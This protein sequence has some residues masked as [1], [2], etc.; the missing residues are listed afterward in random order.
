MSVG[1]ATYYVDGQSGHDEASGLS[2]QHAWKSLEHVNIHIFQAGDKLL[3]Q[4]GTRYVGQLK[5]QGSG[6]IVDGKA[7]NPSPSANMARARIRGLMAKAAFSTHCCSAMSSSGKCRI[8]RSPTSAPTAQP[9]R[10]GVR[11]VCDGFGAM[12][13]IHLRSL[14]VHDVNGDLRKRSR[15]LRHFLREPRRQSTRISMTRHRELP[16]SSAPIATAYAS[17]PATGARSLRRGHSRQSAGRHRRR[18]HQ[19]LGQQR[20]ARS[21]TTFC[22]ADACAARTTRLGYGR[23]IAT[24]RSSSSTKSR[25]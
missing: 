11:V 14:F 12:R 6:K 19:A 23:S 2:P 10:T 22:T 4:A 9:W 25:A 21:S 18:R 13:H 3:F 24:I 15:R 8:W 5:P 17:A 7:A 16:L 1:A 20:R